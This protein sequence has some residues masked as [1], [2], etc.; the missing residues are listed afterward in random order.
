M[1]TLE[2]VVLHGSGWLEAMDASGVQGQPR[3]P[4]ALPQM[5]LRLTRSPAD[6]K[7]VPQ[8]SGRIAMWRNKPETLRR[9]FDGVAAPADLAP[10]AEA[11]FPLE[12]ELGDP[13]GQ[14]LPRVFGFNAGGGAGQRLRMY[15]SSAGTVFGREGGLTGRVRSAGGQPVPWALLTLVVTPPLAAALTYKAQADAHGEFRLA[16]Q[17]LPSGTAANTVYPATL[18]AQATAGAP[19]ASPDPDAQPAA[20]IRTGVGADPAFADSF[21]FDVA[22]GRVAALTSPGQGALVLQLA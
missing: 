22:P 8:A 17:R 9:T 20:D 10:P 2:T 21:V 13:Q 14:F 5:Q 12:G 1:K 19:A 6:L 15:R 3:R 4:L 11:A 16:L 7:L 18:T